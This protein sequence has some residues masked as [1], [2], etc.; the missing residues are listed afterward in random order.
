MNQRRRHVANWHRRLKRTK[1]TVTAT[2][3]LPCARSRTTSAHYC[4]ER[5]KLLRFRLRERPDRL[6]FDLECINQKV[7]RRCFCRSNTS[8]HCPH[9]LTRQVLKATSFR[10]C[11]HRHR[12]RSQSSRMEFRTSRFLRVAALSPSIATERSIE[13][14][15][16]RLMLRQ[17]TL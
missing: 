13:R 14:R 7:P 6:A 1:K 16:C 11:H 15:Q 5:F 3:R 8:D 2:V 17:S 12:P 9:R 4:V 10:H